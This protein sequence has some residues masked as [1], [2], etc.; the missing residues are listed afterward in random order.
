[1]PRRPDPI[2]D[3][4]LHALA[5]TI[6]RLREERGWSVNDLARAADIAP[7]TLASLEDRSNEPRW[8][9]LRRI[10]RALDTELE[11]LLGQAEELER[12]MKQTGDEGP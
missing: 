9:T 5:Q 7:A 12:D 10:A 4:G 11:D 6:V 1:L 2:E 8:G 3:R